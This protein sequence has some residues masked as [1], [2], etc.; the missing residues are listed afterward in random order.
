MHIISCIDRIIDKH[1]YIIK[2]KYSYYEFKI[3]YNLLIINKFLDSLNNGNNMFQPW[4]H[5]VS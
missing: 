4:K 2:P 5:F 1:L 3:L